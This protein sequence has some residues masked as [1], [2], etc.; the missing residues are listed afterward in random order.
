[1]QQLIH[2][3]LVPDGSAARRLRR[4]IAAQS[5]CMGLI[6]GT[7]PE[8]IEQ[9]KSAYVIAN[10]ASDWKARFHG[11][12]ESIPDAFWFNSFEVASEETATEV[13]AAL[14]LLV[15]ATEPGV[16]IDLTNAVQLPERPHKH[17]HDI[18][19]L[20][21]ELE[22]LLPDELL[23]IQQLISQDPSTAIR[24]IAVYHTE[25]SPSLTRWQ[26]ALISKLNADAG[27]ERDAELVRLLESLL[28]DQGAV[29]PQTSLQVLQQQ[30]FASPDEKPS[31]DATV[32]WLGVRDFLQE[33]EVAAGMVQTMLAENQDVTPSDIGLLV[34]DTCAETS[35]ADIS[36]I[37]DSVTSFER[38]M[39][40]HFSPTAV[41]RELPL[42]GIDENGSVV[43]GTADLVLETDDGVWII[44]H[45]SDQI[46]EPEAAFD[47]YRPQLESY[48]KLLQSMGHDVAGM[49]INWI[50]RGEVVL[51]HL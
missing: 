38:W 10:P 33:A 22:G 6:V 26:A 19:K 20:L 50:R 21:R 4:T 25:G 11:A 15:S 30:L 34:P 14:S 40:G 12:L 2:F 39:T 46:D 13:E 47:N 16:D 41:H 51:Q 27:I 48:A 17:V 45:K 9:A 18:A 3:L 8:L 24:Q 44:D 31:L 29:P 5:P 32:Q 7:W 1:M 43:S 23:V 42:L 35:E 37:A 28:L 36:V 49:G